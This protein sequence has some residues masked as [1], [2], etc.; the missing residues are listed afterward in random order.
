M[1][2]PNMLAGAIL[3]LLGRRL[4]WLFVGCIAFSL[5]YNYAQTVLSGYSPVLMMAIS[6]LAGVAGA[7]LAV[8][9][10]DVM[11]GISG[12]LAGIHITLSIAQSSGFAYSQLLLLIGIAGGIMGSL[13]LIFLFDWALILLSSL[14][15]ASVL[16]DA[17]ILKYIS[18]DPRLMPI[19]YLFLVIT[20][21]AVQAKISAPAGGRKRA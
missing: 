3:L 7:M 16:I 19:A 15:G 14:A 20:G 6:I 11:V 1:N 13:L 21:C 12:F 18:S 9:F 5:T 8:F 4:F 10:R 2:F 17:G